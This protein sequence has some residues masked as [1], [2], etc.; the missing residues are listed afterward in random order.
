MAAAKVTIG[1]KLHLTYSTLT[2][3]FLTNGKNG[4]DELGFGGE[5]LFKLAFPFI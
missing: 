4:A 3:T 1:N 5:K 2:I